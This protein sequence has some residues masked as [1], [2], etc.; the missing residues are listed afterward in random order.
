MSQIAVQRVREA[1][2][3]CSLFEEMKNLAE[4]VRQRAF[5]IFQNR[6]G[7]NGSDLDDWYQ[8][9]R[10]LIW[11][12]ES[13]LL[14]KDGKFEMQV[15][16]TGY[17]PKDVHVTALPDAVLV[18]AESTHKHNKSDGDVCFCEFQRSMFR[19]YDLP[20]PIDVDKVTAN[21]DDGILKVTAAKAETQAQ[22]EKTA[23]KS[24]A[25]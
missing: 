21:V 23:E 5:E 7:Q 1:G 14:E 8:A 2:T 6:A 22:T 4:R 3:Q 11:T 20:A 18:T 13:D 9:E 25:A 15:A 19:R 10:E 17:D 12:P 24:M 16:V